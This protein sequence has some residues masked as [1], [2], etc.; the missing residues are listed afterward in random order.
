MRWTDESIA[1]LRDAAAMNRYYETVAERI[2]PQLPENAHICD[3]GCGIGKLSLALKPYCRHVT[4]VDADELA[5]KT[6]EAHLIKGVT[7]ICG[8]V[9][10]LTPKEP[11]DAMVFCLFGRTQDTLR[12]ARKRCRT[13]RRCACSPLRRR[14]FRRR[15]QYETASFDLRERGVGK[16]TLIRRLLEHSTREVGG[17]VTKRLPIADEN[18]FFP[19][20]LYPASQKEDERHNEAANLVGTCDSRSSIRHPEVFDT[21]GAQLIESAPEGGIILMD[22]LGFLENDARAFQSTVMRALD[23]E[24]PVLAAVKPKDTPFLRAVR[25]HENAELVFID[26]QNRDALLEKLLPHILRW[27]EA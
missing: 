12:I 14:L 3:A 18:G 17:F 15:K 16:S 2:A 27:N 10:A 4:A 19:I 9:E 5:I 26:E 22:E 6:L 23:G 7:A 8:D 24:T 1:F 21:L 11:Y 25:G 13:K 20:Y